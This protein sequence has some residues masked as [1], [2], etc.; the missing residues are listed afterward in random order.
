[1]T[2][3]KS[4]TFLNRAVKK[5]AG[6]RFARLVPP[7]HFAKRLFRLRVHVLA[8]GSDSPA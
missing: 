4:F 3:S 2:N 6:G 1:M 7:R 5:K 8:L